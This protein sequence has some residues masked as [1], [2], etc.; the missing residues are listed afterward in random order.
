M[1]KPLDINE[2]DHKALLNRIING[3]IVLYLGSGFS[4]GAIGNLLD[5]DTQ[6]RVPLP[7][8]EQLKKILCNEVLDIEEVEGSLRDI[9]EDCQDDNSLKYARIMREIFNVTLVQEF[10]NMYA[11][12]DWK[13]IFTTNVDNVVEY[14]YGS[15]NINVIYKKNPISSAR[16]SLSYYKLH[17]DAV[18]A[19]EDIT[20]STS[21]Y[22]SSSTA[23]NDCRFEALS[24]AL[25]TENLLFVGASLSEEWDFDIQC[26]QS[27]VY[28]VTNKA[29]FVLPAYN[30]RL[31]KR[32]KRRFKNPVLIK[33]TAESFIYK[34]K[35]YQSSMPLKNDIYTYNKWKFRQIKRENYKLDG[36]LRPNLYLGSEPTWEDIFT[37]HDVIWEKTKNAI[38]IIDKHK[39]CVCTLIIGKSISGKTTMLYRLGVTLSENRIILEYMGDDFI[40]DLSQLL[41]YIKEMDKEIIILLDDA[42]WVLGRI[43][44]I[45][46]LL[47]DGKVHLIASVREKEYQ[48]RQHLFDEH[49]NSKINF[50]EYINKLSDDDLGRY[51]DK[52]SEKS[53]LG[54]YS[55]KYQDS[56]EDTIKM[57]REEI[58]TKREDPL[59]NLAYKMKF[60]SQMDHR[61]DKISE[62]VIKN[63]NYNLKRF[64]VLL[65]FLD[66]IGDTGL[67]WSLFLDLYPMSSDEIKNFVMDI[68][69]LL[70]SNVKKDGWEKSEFCKITIHGR[71]SGI[72]KKVIKKIDT[73]E[74]EEIIEDI[75]R[76]I[77]TQYHFKCRTSNS[78]QN[79]VLYTLLRSQNI[80]ELF[81]TNQKGT[82]EWKYIIRLY[83]NLHEYF[84][85]YHLYWLHRGISEVKMKNYSSATIHLEQARITR[86]GYSYEI[87]H[88]F[89]VL[90]FEQAINS[91]DRSY[92]ERQEMLENALKIIRLQIGRKENDAFSIHTFIV[93]TIQFYKSCKKDVPDKLMKEILENYYLARKQFDLQKSII[94]RN[95]LMCIY[96]YLSS[97]DKVYDY[98]L[99]ITQEELQYVSRRIKNDEIDY[100]IL[101][102]I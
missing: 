88:T 70:I 76:R 20:F 93:K 96:N 72:L 27:D 57:L 24:L 91:R 23:R 65:Y 80:G 31:I 82:T 33:E 59:L 89:S 74:L 37:N 45:M 63:D 10:H 39:E 29:Y 68:Q 26:K 3:D 35:N 83:E 42:N 17:G 64:S 61:I 49:L 55:K 28:L 73:G 60:G 78:Y 102:C 44:R 9:C 46:D 22:I 86:G 52:L 32:I 8:V 56:R 41:L 90:Y 16:G 4:F 79:Y 84:E 12:Y 92:H 94:R 77:D 97:H 1:C 18:R 75:F 30:D 81:N 100:E 2:K 36:Y 50:I 25:K 34:V 101:D 85:D 38:D 5:Q 7:G 6:E 95:M 69:D 98:N 54:Q 19:P 66:V 71:H 40:S 13:N 43:K 48:K 67:K 15:K 87:E 21:D 11:D 47:E 62:N 51:L 58:R 53:F 99:S 14:I